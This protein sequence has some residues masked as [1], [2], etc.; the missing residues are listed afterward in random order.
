LFIGRWNNST[1][2]QEDSISDKKLQ[3]YMIFRNPT[4][5]NGYSPFLLQ[6]V[7]ISKACKNKTQYKG[8]Y[9]SN[10]PLHQ[11][12]DVEKLGKIEEPCDGNIET[13]DNSL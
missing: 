4:G 3:G 8:L 11:E 2:L 1:E 9:F 12:I 13:A 5:R 6:R 10:K 7:N